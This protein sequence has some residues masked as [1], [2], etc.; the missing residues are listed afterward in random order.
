MNKQDGFTLAELIVT[1]AI[2]AIVLTVGIPSFQETM[3]KN[4]AAAHMNEMLT[5]LNLARGEAA[6]RGQRVS[7]CPSTNGAS[8]TG[9]TNWSNGWI[10][11]TDTST[12]DNA[13]I[14]GTVL[15]V[16]EALSGDPT[17]TGPNNLR[18][19]FTGDAIAAGE[20]VHT[21]NAITQR[22]CVSVV[23]RSSIKKDGACP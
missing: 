23:G 12:D 15:R 13:V 7:L 11:F 21:L 4:R 5:V 9:G 8:C 16:G 22:V 10:M 18:Y 19:R 20:F 2:A 14:V 3:R 6:K 1:V 17:F